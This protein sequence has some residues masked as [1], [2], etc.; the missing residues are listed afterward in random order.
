MKSVSV[1]RP[2]QSNAAVFTTGDFPC[3]ASSFRQNWMAVSA[4]N[5]HLNQKPTCPFVTYGV[6]VAT[7]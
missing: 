4:K 7:L 1:Y 5:D 6:L 3:E 2:R